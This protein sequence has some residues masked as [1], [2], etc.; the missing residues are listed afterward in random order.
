MKAQ[1][2]YNQ[3]KF[4]SSSMLNRH[5]VTDSLKVSSSSQQQQ[6]PKQPIDTE[7]LPRTLR[8]ALRPSKT[9][10]LVITE[11]DAPFRIVNVNTCWEQLCGYSYVESKGKTLGSLLRGPQTDPLTATTMIAKL[12]QGENDVGATLINYKKNGEPFYNRIRAGP[13]YN[14]ETGDISHF[15]GL[16]QEIGTMTNSEPS[17]DSNNTRKQRVYA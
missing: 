6:P 4:D 13:I 5:F 1:L 15:V 8:D 16:L 14:E 3:N 10:S 2:H 17:Y 9:R 12:L 7:P 11:K